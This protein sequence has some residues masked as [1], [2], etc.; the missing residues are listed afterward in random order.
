VWDVGLAVLAEILAVGVDD[1]GGVVIDAGLLLFVD[2]HDHDHPVLA[3]ELSHEL[4][5]GAAG[6]GLG[7]R[8]PARLL[9]GAEIRAVEKLLQAQDLGLLASGLLDESHV[10]LDHRL[11]DSGQSRIRSLDVPGLD[12]SAANDARHGPLSF[13]SIERPRVCHRRPRATASPF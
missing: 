13:R 7:E 8:V 12:Q 10:L 5:G 4:G 6:D 9:L 11:L 3:G 2:G 1:G